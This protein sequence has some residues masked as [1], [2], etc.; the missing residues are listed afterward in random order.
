MVSHSVQVVFVACGTSFC[1]KP[2]RVP[3]SSTAVR[4]FYQLQ[5]PSCKGGQGPENAIISKQVVSG[6]VL[7]LVIIITFAG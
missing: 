2:E 4:G 3:G 1:Y 7:Q 6:W 5:L